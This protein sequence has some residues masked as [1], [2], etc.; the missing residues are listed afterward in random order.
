MQCMLPGEPRLEEIEPRDR[1]DPAGGNAATG[2]ATDI[3]V[4]SAAKNA[5]LAINGMSR[6]DEDC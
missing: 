6:E 2:A 1:E 3:A 5:V 4:M